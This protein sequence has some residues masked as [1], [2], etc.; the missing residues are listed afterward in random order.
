MYSCNKYI[1]IVIFCRSSKSDSAVRSCGGGINY[2][3]PHGADK[4][5]T[6]SGPPV[7]SEDNSISTT[8]VEVSMYIT[9][10]GI[11]INLVLHIHKRCSK[12]IC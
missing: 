2:V 11:F 10:C 12:R 3:S 7:L 1:T 4:I 6:V 5:R 8:E 9:F